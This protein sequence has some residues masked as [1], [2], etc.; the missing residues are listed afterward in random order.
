MAASS[1]STTGRVGRRI[2]E[3]HEAD[4]LWVQKR[5]VAAQGS[6]KETEKSIAELADSEL[7]LGK[8]HRCENG[9]PQRCSLVSHS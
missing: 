8:T 5:W 1:V 4:D 3:K 2:D 6:H 9:L 7:G